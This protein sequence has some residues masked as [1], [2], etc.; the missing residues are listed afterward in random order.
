ML[1]VFKTKDGGGG[2]EKWEKMNT[3]QFGNRIQPF[4]YFDRPGAY[5]VICNDKNEI[6]VV[7]NNGLYFLPGGGIENGESQNETVLR[8]V[9][10]ETGI[11]VEIERF[12]GCANEYQIS[13]NKTMKSNQIG[14][15]FKCK[16]VADQHDQSDLSHEFKWID[17]STVEHKISRRSHLWALFLSTGGLDQ[18]E[19]IDKGDTA[20]GTYRLIREDE[21]NELLNLY[22]H[23]NLNDEIHEDLMEYEKA[24]SEIVQN[25]RILYFGA[26]LEKE[27]V[28]TCHLVITPNLTRQCRPYG[29]IE[30]VVT[31]KDLRGNGIGKGILKYALNT[32]W[33]FGCYKVMLMTGSKKE[34]VHRFYEDAGFEKNVKT[35]FLA[36][37]ES[38]RA[39][40]VE[41]RKNG[42]HIA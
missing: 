37:P 38:R 33:A 1:P 27:V 24:W 41:R 36:K 6:G 26:E 10:E 25:P 42:Q 19:L 20:R 29:T 4:E 39:G 28:A 17:I 3:I 34:W 16:R 2:K 30:N 14:Y 5:A 22:S 18:F 15:F 23:L 21:L 8:E 12:L 13:F 7:E 9:R 35:A 31:R 32:A 40:A 11:E